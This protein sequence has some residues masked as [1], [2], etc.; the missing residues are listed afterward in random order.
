MILETIMD[1]KGGI[2]QKLPLLV[3]KI[4]SRNSMFSRCGDWVFEN[5]NSGRV[6]KEKGN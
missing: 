2:A 5:K 1:F 3:S 6:V 4:S